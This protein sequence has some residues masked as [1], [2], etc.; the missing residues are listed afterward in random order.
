MFAVLHIA[1]FALHA[2]LRFEPKAAGR[3]AALLDDS[4]RKAVVLACNAVAR[5]E[6]VDTGQTAAQALA[7][8]GGL[9]LQTR[10]SA[11]EADA[12]ATLLA[13]A[14]AVS[15]KVEA[16]APGTCTADVR[17][18]DAARQRILLRASVQRLVT[19]GLPTTGGLAATPLLALYAARN[20]HVC[21]D[22]PPP[23]IVVEDA[24]AFLAPLP[25][26]M[27]EPEPDLA[28]VLNAWGVHTL[29]QL[30]T[31]PKA[32]VAHRLGPRGLALWER[33]AGET[34]RVLR[35]V[36]PPQQFV[37]AMEFEHEVET[38]EPLL[39]ILRRFVDRLALE[40]EAAHLAAVRLIL[41]LKLVDGTAH[42]RTFRLPEPTQ[43]GDV[44]FRVLHTHLEQLR[45]ESPVVAAGLRV[46]ADRSPVRQRGL[47]ETELDDPH[48][49][50][51]TLARV[52][53]LLPGNSGSDAVG[54]PRVL[55]SHRPDAVIM[56]PPPTVVPPTQPTAPRLLPLGLPLRRFRPPLAARV[57]LE[58][59]RPASVW[60]QQVRGMIADWRGP[61][62]GAGDWWEAGRAWEREEW[63]V[64]FSG[65]GLY[66]L[67]RT[68]AG[69]FVEGEYD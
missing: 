54:T 25:L 51:E 23:V 66:R 9:M 1:D 64:E 33:A 29:G 36:S 32:E 28:E 58:N 50:A 61:W 55:D 14:F 41:K 59:G 20:R 11:A 35:L 57:A 8:C 46:K 62:F 43:K 39:F 47:F 2:A 65:G 30:T 34:T 15:P 69:W 27:A 44:L 3:P 10:Q 31:L 67:M 45:T 42:V 6:G 48:G 49:F 18:L 38:L 63:D 22:G 5:A 16:T 7:H 37:A 21:R 17:G 52:G 53:A 56:E 24:A 13:A 12:Q 4:S 26:A 68:P 60:S 40:I 19:F